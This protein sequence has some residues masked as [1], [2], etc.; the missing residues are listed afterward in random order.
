MRYS[1]SLLILFMIL[2]VSEILVFRILPSALR[3]PVILPFLIV[4]AAD[5]PA[6][7]RA[8]RRALFT[9]AVIGGIAAEIGSALPPGV[10]LVTYVVTTLLLFLV[11]QRFFAHVSM[12]I[13][14]LAVL[15][16]VISVRL[17]LVLLFSSDILNLRPAIDLVRAIVSFLV[18][19]ALFAVPIALLWRFIVRRGG[20]RWILLSFSAQDVK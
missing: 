5:L 19:P 8:P 7:T 9:F 13:F 3:V 18:I 15:G 10:L 17:L 6:L 4:L 20:L 12:G 1:L 11:L 16:G 14:I 2:A